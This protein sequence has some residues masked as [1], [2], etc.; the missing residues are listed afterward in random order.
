MVFSA[1][2]FI[3]V[4]LPG[5]WVAYWLAARVLGMK[6]A[7]GILAT[8]SVVFYSQWKVDHVA[9][10]LVS[11]C[12]NYYFSQRLG[13]DRAASRLCLGIGLSLNL[14]ALFWFK[15]A[16]FASTIGVQL[17][18]WR[19]PLMAQALPLGISFFTF[20]QITYLVD[21]HKGIAPPTT[22]PRFLLFVSFFPH[23][24]AGPVLHHAQMMPQFET[25]RL[26]LEKFCG[27]L[28]IFAIGLAKKCI[29]ADSVAPLAEAGFAQAATL[30]GHFA[31]IVLLAYAVQLYFDFSGYSDMAVGLGRLFGIE[32]PWNFLSPYKATSVVEF[33]RRWHIT[34]S[35][36]LREYI[37]IPLGGSRCG[38]P[39]GSANLLVTMFAA[40]VWHGAGW[41][42]AA[43]GALHGVALTACHLWQRQERFRL[44]DWAGWVLTLATVLPGWVLFRCRTTQDAGAMLAGL[45]S[46]TEGLPWEV[47]RQLGRC[48][49][50][51][52]LGI[53]LV[54]FC[55][56]TRRLAE[57]F[58]PNGWRTAWTSGL[59]ALAVVYELA[60]GADPTFLY[61][62]F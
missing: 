53:L 5:A 38:V 14:L 46:P 31:W 2:E 55:P 36:F 44:P 29:I 42:F 10:L 6:W 21:R 45:L 35:N 4:F 11:V 43:W 26:S 13:P 47:D 33:W 57:T 3:F 48:G 16:V 32:L 39:R 34:L 37:Y 19:T 40:G 8:M 56:N 24:I 58:R 23:L 15:Y 12:V 22:F 25:N 61:F 27:G 41:T 52:L 18:L 28:H 7:V 50:Y 59:L 54:L 51:L 60:R 17:G 49:F 9:V 62:D 1:F 20:T 30:N